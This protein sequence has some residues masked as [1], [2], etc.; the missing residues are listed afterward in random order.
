[1]ADDMM[2]KTV[3]AILTAFIAVILVASAFIPTAIDQITALTAKYADTESASS[4]KGYATL[5]G[6]V[7]TI[8]IVAIIIGIVKSYFFKS[9]RRAGYARSELT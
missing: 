7:I 8:T 2:E 4:V 6:V 3:S 1:M 5:I 9:D